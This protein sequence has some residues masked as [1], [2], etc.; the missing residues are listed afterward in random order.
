MSGM[1]FNANS[2]IIMLNRLFRF[3]I[4]YIFIILIIRHMLIPSKKILK[5][6]AMF[7]NYLH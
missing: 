1:P 5:N 3:F 6:A 2:G 4:N 7:F